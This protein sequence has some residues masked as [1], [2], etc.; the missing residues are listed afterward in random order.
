MTLVLL[1]LLLAVFSVHFDFNDV[2]LVAFLLSP[3]GFQLSEGFFAEK[4]L[5]GGGLTWELSFG[6]DA[7]FD[8]LTV[9]LWDWL[10]GDLAVDFAGAEE[11]SAFQSGL[12]FGTA[13]LFSSFGVHFGFE[14]GL[15]S[16]DSLDWLALVFLFFLFH[17]WETDFFGLDFL[18]GFLDLLKAH[19]DD[20]FFWL[21]LFL[22]LLGA[23]AQVV[24]STEWADWD[25]VWQAQ[26]GV[27][28]DSFSTDFHTA[29]VLDLF[30][31]LTDELDF[32]D[33]VLT[34]PV[35][36]ED[37]FLLSFVGKMSL[38]FW[39]DVAFQVGGWDGG[40]FQPFN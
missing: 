16:F 19:F 4:F 27:V 36:S 21:L 9:Q 37:G 35:F 38:L 3:G 14:D 15:E 5:E 2:V 1:F 22:W 33:V 17:G 24:W 6:T 32:A 23:D 7:Q 39:G 13:F 18:F 11:W 10:D 40:Y 31:N 20:E 25:V 29:D 26:L 8:L 28:P 34:D 12:D 30:F